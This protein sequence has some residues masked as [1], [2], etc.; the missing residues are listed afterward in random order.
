MSSDIKIE[1]QS[2]RVIADGKEF[3]NVGCYEYLTGWIHFEIEPNSP[4]PTKI[5]DLENAC[6][7]EHDN[8]EYSSQI[9]ILHSVDPIKSNRRYFLTMVTVVIR[10]LSS[11]SMMPLPLMNQ[12]HQKNAATVF[13]LGEAIL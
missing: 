3:G 4:L 10:E 2:A 7:N 6:K 9:H 8:V 12:F 5:V 1:L 11:I 13:C